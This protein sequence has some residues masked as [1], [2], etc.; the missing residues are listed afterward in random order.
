M[1]Y[2]GFRKFKNPLLF[3]INFSK[4]H[5]SIKDAV[6]EPDNLPEN[7]F[8]LGISSKGENCIIDVESPP[9]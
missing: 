9:I 5:F 2:W 3:Y 4:F 6:Y 1:G 7:N 8:H